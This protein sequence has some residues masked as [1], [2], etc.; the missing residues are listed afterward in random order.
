MVRYENRGKDKECPDIRVQKINLKSVNLRILFLFFLFIVSPGMCGCADR[1]TELLLEEEQEE[2]S[3]QA[4][5]TADKEQEKDLA[6]PEEAVT[7]KPSSVPAQP[8]EEIYV[9]VCGAVVQPGVYAMKSDSRVFQ[10]IEAAGGFLPDAAGTSIN[11]ACALS[12]GQQIYV[13]TKEEAEKGMAGQ[14]SGGAADPGTGGAVTEAAGT[15]ETQDSG[16]VNL[17]TADSA[18]LQTLPGIGEAKAQAILAYRE[19]KGGF[20][21]TEEL[22]NVPG[23]KEST[24]SKIKDKIAVE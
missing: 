16:T 6:S 21:G 5:E 14:P 3:A 20:S 7:E 8:P 22:M 9:D 19:E 12:D 1:E 13:P 18:A 2:L 24:F 11:Q 23:I 17:N 10:A 4:E 15:G